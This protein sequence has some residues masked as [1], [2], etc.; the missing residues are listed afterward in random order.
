MDGHSYQHENT[1][2]NIPM[3]TF[4]GEYYSNLFQV[5]DHIGIDTCIRRFEYA[6]REDQKQYFRFFSNFH[7]VLP[8]LSNGILQ[9]L[10]MTFLYVWWMIVLFLIPPQIITPGTNVTETETLEEYVHRARLPEKFLD[11]YLLPLFSSVAT[12]SHGDLRRFPAAYITDYIKGT[13]RSQHRTVVNMGFLERQLAGGAKKRFQS[14]VVSVSSHE[15]KVFVDYCRCQ[16]STMIQ[17]EFDYAIL[18]T[19]PT[20]T[21]QIHKASSAVTGKLQSR[22]VQIFVFPQQPKSLGLTQRR[23]STELLILD[24]S[25]TQGMDRVTRSTH[26][27]PSGVSV[28]VAAV[29][30]HDKETQGDDLPLH[31]VR[32]WRPLPTPDSHR[33]LLSVFAK[34]RRLSNTGWKNGDGNIYLAGGYASAGLPL[35]EACVRSG[36]EA[37]EAIGALL[38]FHLVRK[39]PF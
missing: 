5:L 37:T 39:T 15:N 2:I 3:R 26:L 17:E 18:A 24:T 30:S 9:N 13:F 10:Y 20:V 38:P 34:D 25:E 21:S 31:S 32:L 35:L 14:E 28:T 22:S 23:Q 33:L 29:L 19:N 4:S 8:C 11:W 6:Y 7:K 16:N 12:C 36:L 27:H 1:A